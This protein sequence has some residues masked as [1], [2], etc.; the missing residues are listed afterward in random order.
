M[1]EQDF[2]LYIEYC[3]KYIVKNSINIINDII[4]EFNNR[5]NEPQENIFDFVKK[6]IINT[7]RKKL[8]IFRNML[9]IIE[10][11]KIMYKF[12]SPK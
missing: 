2:F 5:Y 8:I 7:L 6:I 4:K 12:I 10:I 3:Y 11:I 9:N 1:D